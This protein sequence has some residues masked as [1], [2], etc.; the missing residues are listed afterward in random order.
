M[1]R[2]IKRYDNGGKTGGPTG[3]GDIKK[4]EDAIAYTGDRKGE[5]KYDV[6]T[7][8]SIL[9]YTNNLG[10]EG[11]QEAKDA[12]SSA[13]GNVDFGGG[14]MN[15]QIAAAEAAEAAHIESMRPIAYRDKQG[16][17]RVTSKDEESGKFNPATGV[18]AIKKELLDK[19]VG[20]E[21]SPSEEKEFRNLLQ[22]P[23]F[24]DYFIGIQEEEPSKKGFRKVKVKKKVGKGAANV[25]KGTTGGGG[26]DCK[27]DGKGG[28]TGPG[29]NLIRQ[30]RSHS[31]AD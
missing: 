13:L 11:E 3:R 7:L 19:I 12:F 30:G 6:D 28:L 14:S 1:P 27:P 20:K 21:L 31:F 16:N 8:L 4:V 5:H 9:K 23:A 17:L 22:E 10:G 15:E 24:L 18:S 29:C 26:V 25:G 2:L